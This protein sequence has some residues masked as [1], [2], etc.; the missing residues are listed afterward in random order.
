VRERRE[1]RPKKDLVSKPQNPARTGGSLRDRDI[2][3][4]TKDK[5]K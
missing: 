5:Y 2:A 4:K 3:G 1:K